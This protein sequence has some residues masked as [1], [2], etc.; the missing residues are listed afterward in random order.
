MA[1]ESNKHGKASK[2]GRNYRIGGENRGSTPNTA[3][4][5]KYMRS[6]GAERSAQRKAR[7]HGCNLVGLH[8]KPADQRH[9]HNIITPKAPVVAM[10]AE[11]IV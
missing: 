11:P 5:T 9:A 8:R 3:S 2:A 1:G 10:A 7:N 6:G 4:T